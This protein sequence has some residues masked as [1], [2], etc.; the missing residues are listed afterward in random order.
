MSESEIGLPSTVIKRIVK[1]RLA[2]Q[3][4]SDDGKPKDV[5]L[6]KEALLAFG[7]SA[8]V[9]INYLTAMANDI[10]H[11]GKRQTISAE[12]V[13]KA[14]AEMEF[15]EL[16]PPLKEALQG[17]RPAGPALP[18]GL[19]RL[20]AG[21]GAGAAA[22][23]PEHP[24]GR[25]VAGPRPEH[26]PGLPRPR[27]ARRRAARAAPPRLL[28]RVPATP[29]RW[30]RRPPRTPHL[31]APAAPR[32]PSPL[33]AAFKASAKEKAAQKA[34]AKKRKA[35]EQEEGRDKEQVGGRRLAGW[36]RC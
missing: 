27:G 29:R 34:E 36:W 10:C 19:A 31:P 21:T 16:V 24:P 13:F 23:G 30:P 1:A 26:P 11:E 32:A 8:K 17:G 12:D 6:S 3:F 7:E 2:E 9:F 20:A 33:P 22:G 35:D 4:S 15:D 25:A 18:A 28:G 14:L 5:N